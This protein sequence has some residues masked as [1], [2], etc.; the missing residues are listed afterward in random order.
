VSL[1]PATPLVEILEKQWEATLFASQTGLAPM[2]G[3]RL[4]YHTLRS[5]GSRAGFPDRVMVRD[6]V[7][8]AES[9]R[10]LTGRAS[11]DRDRQPSESQREWLDGLTKAGMECYLWRPSDLDDI[12]K[13]LSKRW[14]FLPS[15]SDGG[16]LHDG[17]SFWVPKSLWV[18]EVGRFDEMNKATAPDVPGQTT[19]HDFLP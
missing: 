14:V 13:I 11:T 2:L 9:K 10:E 4:V 8:F 12:A 5:K 15:A 19:I 1:A 7:I 17:E 6:R 16:R 18:A 3:W